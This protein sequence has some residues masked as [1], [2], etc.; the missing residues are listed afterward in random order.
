MCSIQR[1]AGSRPRR[2]EM[3]LSLPDPVPRRPPFFWGGGEHCEGL[4]CFCFEADCHPAEANVEQV[5]SLVGRLS[6]VN[7]DP[8]S[9]ADIYR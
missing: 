2:T 5:F 4:A 6:E 8:H 7:L 1:S 9:L 3:L